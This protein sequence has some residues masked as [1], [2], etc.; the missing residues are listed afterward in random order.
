MAAKALLISISVHPILKIERL[1]VGTKL[2]LYKALIRSIMTYACPR[3]G[4]HGGQP[5]FE[6]AASAK[7]SSPHHW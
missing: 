5:S 6:I 2:T 3:M 7:L 4:I 1:I